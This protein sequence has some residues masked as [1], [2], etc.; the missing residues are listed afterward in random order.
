MADF[1]QLKV[2]QKAHEITLEIYRITQTF[3]KNETYGLISQMRRAAISN[4]CNLAED[5]G[6]DGD[7]E[8]ARFIQI[9]SGSAAELEYQLLVAKD[10]GY[11][12][13]N[14]CHNL[15]LRLA[16]VGRMLVSLIGSV[17]SAAVG[18]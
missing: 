6:R 3:P 1:R 5:R 12:A 13:E 4:G 11:L 14:E 16:G 10:I 18:S 8:F 7:A 15:E 9:A 2:W 17:K